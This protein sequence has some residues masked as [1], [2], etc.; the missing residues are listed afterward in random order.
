[1]G[2]A[3]V[4][5][6]LPA[7]G[8]VVDGY[9]SYHVR[10]V[11]A[12]QLILCRGQSDQ[13]TAVIPSAARNRSLRGVPAACGVGVGRWVDARS[14]GRAGAFRLSPP[15]SA[16]GQPAG[17]KP[18]PARR[19]HLPVRFCGDV[20]QWESGTRK[21]EVRSSPFARFGPKM[22]GYRLVIDRSR[23]RVPPSPD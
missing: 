9:R 2:A 6:S 11:A 17:R 23:V 14:V 4:A 1:M 22:D 15:G 19:H 20:A 18:Y 16:G 13:R 21:R 5:G 7:D 3:S 12:P 8:P 10:I